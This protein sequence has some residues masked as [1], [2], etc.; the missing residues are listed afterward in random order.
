MFKPHFRAS[1]FV[2]TLSLISFIPSSFAQIGKPNDVKSTK[3]T[4][5]LYQNLL[6]FSNSEQIM[7][8]HQ[9]DLAYGVYWK[10][11]PGRSDVKESS[12][13]YPAVYGWDV[14]KL[15]QPY[16][17]DS[18]AFS[19]MLDWIKEGYKR[20]G[21]I[22]ISWHMDNPVTSGNSW[23][24]TPAVDA[25]LPGGEKHEFYKRRL[26]DF[27]D[28]VKK[29]KVGLSKIPIIFRPFHEHTGNWFWWG[30]GNVSAASYKKLWRFTVSYLRDEKKLHNILYAYSTD[31][32]KNEADY[33]EYYPGDDVIDI[34]AFDD[35]HGISAK[36]KLP[37]FVDRLKMLSKLAK[38][39]NKVAALSESGLETIPID[40]W[41]TE[42]VLESIKSDPEASRIAWMLMWR[43]GRPDHHYAPYKGHK[44]AADFRK[45][46][47]DSMIVLENELPNMYRKKRE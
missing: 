25:I 31:I 44:S 24:N 38:E 5:A 30:K 13:S 43:N 45:F 14:S 12:G 22:T 7:F 6:Y 37:E 41:W 42:Y 28:F 27:A 11:E 15:G 10:D 35:Y 40:N 8:G 39:R 1:F 16:N 19:R 20:G 32:F 2:L 3:K 33:L 26:D 9:D 29:M 17:I 46:C 34:L 36:E 18:V 23:D 47:D 21:I 4:R